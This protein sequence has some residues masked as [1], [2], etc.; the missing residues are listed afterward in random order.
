ME[1]KGVQTGIGNLNRD[2]QAANRLMR[3]IRQTVRSLKGWLS[4]LKEKKAAL[5][6]ALTQTREPT[7]PELLSRYM[8]LRRAG[9]SDWTARGQLKGAVSDFNNVMAAIDFLREKEISTVE[10]LDKRLDEISQAALSIRQGMKK[11]EKRIKAIDTML[12]YID[13]YEATKPVHAEYAAIR[14]KGKKE[15]LIKAL[16]KMN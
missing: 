7:L 6:E 16:L 13:S 14:W 12:S 10:S 3:S 5:M 4:D 9:R 1:K 11:S 2:I 15:K 8:D